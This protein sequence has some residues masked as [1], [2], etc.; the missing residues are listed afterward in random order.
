[1]L[2]V[3]DHAELRHYLAAHLSARYQVLSAAGGEEALTLLGTH[4][5]AAI[6]SDIMMPGMDGLTMSRHIRALPEVASTPIV[7]VSA[8]ASEVDLLTGLEVAD[9]YLTKP[10]RVREL[11]LRLDR[12]IKQRQRTQGP[13]EVGDGHSEV[14]APA[15]QT[16]AMADQ[17]FL[18]RL[19]AQVK[20]HMADG[21][22][23]VSH[24]AKA[25]A[26]SARQLRR[27][28]QRLAGMSTAEY[29]RQARMEEARRLLAAGQF[30]TVGE[31]AAE[32]GM[33]PSY[34]SRL[35]TTWYGKPPSEDLF[36]GRRDQPP[37]KG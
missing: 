28:V 17:Q 12:L 13:E 5:P 30:T 23:G 8:K 36:K 14:E 19:E 18:E 25:M 2:L 29:L 15:S 1:M 20:A 16:L 26:L 3:E 33:T 32:V 9:D 37:L 11:I 4:R 27:T 7:L 10:V 22:F 31:V 21:G 24:L 6:V 35:Y 34:F